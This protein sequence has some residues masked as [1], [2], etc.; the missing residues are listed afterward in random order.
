[1]TEG[2]QYLLSKIEND[3]AFFQMKSDEYHIKNPH[4]RDL[5]HICQSSTFYMKMDQVGILSA[6]CGWVDSA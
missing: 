4:A 3:I 1:M 5:S 2:R 6:H